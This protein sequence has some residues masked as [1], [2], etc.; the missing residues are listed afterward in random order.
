M[1]KMIRVKGGALLVN[2][3]AVGAY[4]GAVWQ[5]AVSPELSKAPDSPPLAAF[6]FVASASSSMSMPP[7]LGFLAVVD[8]ISDEPRSVAPPG[9]KAKVSRG[10]GSSTE[11]ST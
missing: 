7:G 11:P 4:L 1:F 10:G 3:A 2:T 6:N 5:H 9:T 8:S